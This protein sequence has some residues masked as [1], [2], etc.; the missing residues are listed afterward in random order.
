MAYDEFGRTPEQAERDRRGCWIG[1]L[2]AAALIALVV[3][4]TCALL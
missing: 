4:A 3:L 1:C 2:G